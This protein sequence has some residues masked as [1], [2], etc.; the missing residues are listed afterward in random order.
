MQFSSTAVR[1]RNYK[2]KG[3]EKEGKDISII[4]YS[5]ILLLLPGSDSSLARMMKAIR[6]LVVTRKLVTYSDDNR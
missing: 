5:K 6:Q 1:R 2:G 4:L 3:K